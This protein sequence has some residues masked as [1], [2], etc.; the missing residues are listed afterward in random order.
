MRITTPSKAPSLQL[1]DIENTPIPVGGT[2]RKMLLSFFREANCPFCNFRVY[3]LTH[4]YRSLDA[5]GLDIV[6]V[7]SSDEAQ[8]RRFVARQ[9]RPFRMVADPDDSAH[10]IFG[11]ERSFMGKLLAMMRR[12]PAMIRGM[13]E[14][15]MAGMATGN[16]LPA[17]FLIDEQGHVV[18][19]Y[20][21]RDAGDHIPIERI[22][23]FV[24]R[25]L[26][27]RPAAAEASSQA[28]SV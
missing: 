1:V 24:A 23:L 7:F 6:A 17:D 2:G 11:V 28:R 3:E 25:G 14:V 5:L 10:R 12:L 13:R 26:A 20:Y 9:P 22:E 27:S 4:N 8:I 21:G 18:E 19:T 16:L 15:G